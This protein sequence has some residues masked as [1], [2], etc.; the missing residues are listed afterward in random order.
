MT[1]KYLM[2]K[3][4][5]QQPD[6]VHKLL[7]NFDIGTARK[8]I[9]KVKNKRLIFTGMGSSFYSVYSILPQLY[10]AGID[11]VSIE[12][13]ELLHYFNFDTLNKNDVLILISQSGESI[14]V[15]KILNKKINCL[16]VGI[17]NNSES[18][19]A[20]NVEMLF[21]LHAGQEHM[22]ATKTYLNTVVLL[23][24]LCEFLCN[25]NQQRQ[26]IKKYYTLPK[27]IKIVIDKCL[28]AKKYGNL[29]NMISEKLKDEKSLVIIGRG[30][31]LSAVYQ[32]ALLMKE[33]ARI[34]AEAMSVG[35]FRHGPIEIIYPG[36]NIIYMNPRGKTFDVNIKFIKNLISKQ[37]NLTVITDE[38]LKEFRQN[39]KMI[40]F[41]LPY[42]E[43][44]FFSMLS[45]IPIEFL[46]VR[47]AKLRGF[48]P[49][50][51]IHGSKV[52]I[53]E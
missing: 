12:S 37:V 50:K 25:E 7:D 29:L 3:E 45:I 15:K 8:F 18:Y 2:E 31:I 30:N 36:Y 13:S 43:E 49:G 24:L 28:S 16:T 46:S 11:V 17:T 27:V 38:I 51:F 6:A 44:K 48:I 23:N 19:L 41:S 34:Q 10:A 40:I 42:V 22:S 14:E 9:N 35:C 33:V 52:T 32:S 47:I 53:N 26:F 1:I 5:L 20:K 4:I 21:L 39:E